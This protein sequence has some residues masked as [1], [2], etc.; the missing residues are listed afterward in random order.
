MEKAQAALKDVMMELDDCAFPLLVGMI[1]TADPMEAFKDAD[2]ALL[3][4]AM[5]RGPGMERKD[6]LLKNAEIFT[7]QGKALRSEEHTSELPSLMRHSY[8]VF[9]LKKKTTQ[10]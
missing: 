7:V 10:H 2:V 6:L 8:A 3:V 4:G 5:P 1:G 9:C